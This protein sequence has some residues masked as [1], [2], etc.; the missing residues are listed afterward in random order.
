MKLLT[1]FA[2]IIVLVAAPAFADDAVSFASRGGEAKVGPAD[3]EWFIA[4]SFSFG[5]EREMK[6]SREGPGTLVLTMPQGF[7]GSDA[8]RRYQVSGEAIPSLS[9]IAPSTNATG[10]TVYL[11]YKLDRCFVKSWST[12]GDADDRPTE[13]VAFYYNKIAF[14]YAKTKDG[15]EW[16]SDRPMKW[17][18]VKN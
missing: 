6:A 17:N 16:R 1:A 7:K 9:L 14:A 11:R 12:S 15:K 5:V 2:A 8:L 4:D 13:E 10:E 3:N 18:N